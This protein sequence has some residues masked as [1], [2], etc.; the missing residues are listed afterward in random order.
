MVLSLLFC[1]YGNLLGCLSEKRTDS[2]LSH[3][4]WRGLYVL[5]SLPLHFHLFAGLYLNLFLSILMCSIISFNCLF[6]NNALSSGIFLIW[7]FLVR[8]FMR[9]LI[10]LFASFI[11]ICRLSFVCYISQS[12]R[13]HLR[14]WCYGAVQDSD[15]SPTYRSNLHNKITVN[16]FAHES[17]SHRL[18]N[19]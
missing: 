18:G 1:L 3:F 7:L 14:M 4:I 19:I 11:F 16:T 17:L 2:N 9:H 12:F 5:Y 13:A 8:H 10:Y 6:I 15:S